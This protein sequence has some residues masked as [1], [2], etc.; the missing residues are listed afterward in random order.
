MD[1]IN[2][3]LKMISPSNLRKAISCIDR[4]RWNADDKYRKINC[5]KCHNEI[6]RVL[7]LVGWEQTINDTEWWY[8]ACAQDTIIELY[9]TVHDKLTQL[10]PDIDSSTKTS[11]SNTRTFTQMNH[12]TLSSSQSMPQRKKKRKTTHNFENQQK[13]YA[14]KISKLLTLSDENKRRILNEEVQ[15]TLNIP[16]KTN[17]EYFDISVLLNNE[18]CL[19]CD[20]VL[21]NKANKYICQHISRHVTT[22]V[23]NMNTIAIA[24]NNTI[25]ITNNNT[26]A[27][28][29][30]IEP[31]KLLFKYYKFMGELQRHMDRMLRSHIG[32]REAGDLLLSSA[33][34]ITKIVSVTQCNNTKDQQIHYDINH[35]LMAVENSKSSF[36]RLAWHGVFNFDNIDAICAQGEGFNRDY[37]IHRN[38][39][40]Y[41]KGT[42][43]ASLDNPDYCI[44]NKYCC[45][46]QRGDI[47]ILLCSIIVVNLVKGNADIQIVK[48][49][50]IT[51]TDCIA[52]PS[53]LVVNRDYHAIPLYIIRFRK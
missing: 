53:I 25:A 52:K 29:N 28:A 44:D 1:T 22:Y 14:K 10:L 39:Q 23:E 13:D 24:N 3:E 9:D 48:R 43:F 30:K 12:N 7:L 21:L 42:Y 27:I 8:I 5:V 17:K 16:A 11:P 40:K 32:K 46:D 2:S 6:V 4:A 47:V 20:K 15:M 38:R 45:N 34:N 41:G 33:R 51:L 50:N 31:F 35:R 49:D 37:S 19:V 26:I 18:T 36:V